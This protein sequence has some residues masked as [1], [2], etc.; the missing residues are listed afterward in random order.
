M[1]ALRAEKAKLLGYESYRRAEARRHHGQDAEGGVST[2]S[3]RSG[4]RRARRPPPTRSE[5]QRLAAA[6][7]SNDKIAAWDWRF[8]QE[9]LRAEKFAFDEAELKPYLQ[10][11]RIIDACFDVATRLFGVTFAEKPGIAGL[12]SRRARLRGAATRDGSRRGLF[13]ADYFARPSKRSGAWMSALQSGYKLGQGSQPDHLQRHELRQAAPKAS[14]RCCRS[15]RPAR[16]STN[17][18]MRCTAC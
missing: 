1:L 5:L 4:R 8:Y 7:G 16:C 14:R 3:T 6:A 18:A 11:D 15:T 9:K 17:S 2:C 13:L 12:A 10:L